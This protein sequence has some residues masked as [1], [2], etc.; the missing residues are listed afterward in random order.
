VLHFD[1]FG[2]DR[3]IGSIKCGYA[4][5]RAGIAC[6][7]TQMFAYEHRYGTAGVLRN[8]RFRAELGTMC[9]IDRD[10]AVSTL[11]AR[12]LSVSG[13]LLSH[14]IHPTPNWRRRRWRPRASPRPH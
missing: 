9:A 1:N 10:G 6:S 3:Q 2:T 14:I 4:Q 11:H 8:T 5:W 7:L 13:K 12:F